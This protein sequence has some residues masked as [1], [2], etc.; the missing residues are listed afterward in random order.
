MRQLNVAFL[1][2]K[3]YKNALY[4]AII[5]LPDISRLR[6][7]HKTEECNTSRVGINLAKTERGYSYIEPICY[8]C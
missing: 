5:K 7:R 6:P 2:I 1:L 3:H 4:F 8:M